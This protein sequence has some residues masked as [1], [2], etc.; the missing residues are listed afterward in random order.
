MNCTVAFFSL[1]GHGLCE[2]TL[3]RCANKVFVI[4]DFHLQLVDD[5]DP[6]RTV[7]RDRKGVWKLSSSTADQDRP[8]SLSPKTGNATLPPHTLHC[9]TASPPPARPCPIYRLPSIQ[10]GK[11]VLLFHIVRDPLHSL[12]RQS[13][14]RFSSPST[15]VVCAESRS[16]EPWVIGRQQRNTRS[17]QGPE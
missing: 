11:T 16:M 5:E 17:K 3:V 4:E 10:F 8:V 2:E 14:S 7:W 15:T 6:A 13:W 1:T 9:S 12:L